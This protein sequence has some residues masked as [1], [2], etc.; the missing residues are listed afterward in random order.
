MSEAGAAQL[1]VLRA[2]VIPDVEGDYRRFA[3]LVN[4][5]RQAVLQNKL[6]IRYIDIALGSGESSR[7]CEQ[8]NQKQS[9]ERLAL[10]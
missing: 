10:E 8:N 6:L 3:I 4:D 9:G 2:Y 7:E 1:L 5:Q